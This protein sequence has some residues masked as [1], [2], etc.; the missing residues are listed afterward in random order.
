ME[1]LK[2]IDTG[3]LTIK[4]IDKLKEFPKEYGIQRMV[5]KG[6]V[7]RIKNS[8]EQLYIPS[9][10]KVNKNWYILDG[11]HSKQALMELAEGNEDL[12]IVYVMYDTQGRDRET[13][14][15]LNTTSKNWKY[16][17]FMNIWVN[18]GNENYIW[19]KEFKE[20]HNLTY[21]T[22]MYM[23][24]GTDQGGNNKNRDIGKMF[25]NGE[26]VI[27]K[28]QRIRATRIVEQLKEVKALIPKEVGKIRN[29]QNAFTKVAL[30][31]KYDHERMINKL[32]YQYN[33]IHKCSSKNAYVE[34]LEDIYNY[35]SKNKDK[36]SFM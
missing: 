26:L 24:L 30:N 19:F 33:R 35:K 2:I 4:D 9:V 8:M 11:Q 25:N 6:N 1:S 3:V 36:I 32:D 27:T 22:A 18:N 28:E 31:E 16:D 12:Q 7:D 29:F 15:L 10:I 14:I 5:D 13:C 17:D 20:G 23:C 21:I 34:M